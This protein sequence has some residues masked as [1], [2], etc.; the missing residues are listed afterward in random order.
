MLE[1]SNIQ[2][3]QDAAS[4]PVTENY[5][6]NLES[7]MEAP[8]VKIAEGN[9]IVDGNH[10]YIAGRVFGKEPATVPGTLSPSMAPYKR[11][12]QEIKLDYID[13]GNR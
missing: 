11:P 12:I 13:W 6:R 10:P 1:G 9:I 5:I 2:T 7:G 4:V 8:A 3:V